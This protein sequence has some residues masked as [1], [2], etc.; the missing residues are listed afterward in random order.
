MGPGE[1]FCSMEHM[2]SHQIQIFGGHSWMRFKGKEIVPDIQHH[3][4][5]VFEPVI[6]I[7]Q[8]IQVVTFL[9]W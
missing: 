8:A 9:G 6:Y 2:G 3:R 7:Y 1:D 5:K 4:T